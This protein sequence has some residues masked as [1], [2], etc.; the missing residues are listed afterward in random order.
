[1]ALG[2]I[3][4]VFVMLAGLRWW[5]DRVMGADLLRALVVRTLV[6]GVAGALAWMVVLALLH[7]RHVEIKNNAFTITLAFLFSGILQVG[8]TLW[9]A[10]RYDQRLLEA[11]TGITS[12]RGL[13]TV[14]LPG[15]SSHT[16]LAFAEWRLS[17]RRTAC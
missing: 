17:Y 7:W 8:L 5:P 12:A 10:Q 14:I 1:M 3:F 2:A 4:L 6:F 15:G 16:I 11:A 9:L 13:V